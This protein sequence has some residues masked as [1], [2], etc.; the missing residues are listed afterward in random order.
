MELG[1]QLISAGVVAIEREDDQSEHGAGGEA[2]DQQGDQEGLP[3]HDRV[4]DLAHDQAS[5]PT[6]EP[7]RASLRASWRTPPRAILPSLV[8]S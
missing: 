4:Q 6:R 5:L 1:E 8:S 3:G 2:E 7:N